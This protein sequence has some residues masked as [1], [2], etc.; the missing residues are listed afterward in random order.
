MQGYR[1]P[2]GNYRRPGRRRKR[3]RMNP[4][5]LIITVALSL[6]AVFV[7]ALI[8]R[9][10]NPA[11]EAVAQQTPSSD[12]GALVSV[13]A[14]GLATPT[15][16]PAPTPEATPEPAPEPTPEP[17]A[18]YNVVKPT[19]TEEGYLPICRKGETNEKIICITVDDCFQ[20]KNTRTIIDLVLS[21][22]GKITLFPIGKNVLRE[23]LQDT[24]RYAYDMGMEIENHTYEHRPHYNKDDELMARQI[25]MQKACVDYVLGVDYEQHFF[26]P[27]GGDGRDDQRMHIYCEQ[28]GIYGV[29]YWSVSGSDSDIARIKSSLSPGQVYL[30]HTTDSDL[31]KLK[32]FIPYAVEQGYTLVTMNEMFGLPENEVKPLDGPV[33]DRTI[34]QIG[35]YTLN[36]RTYKEGD[37]A[38]MAYLIQE[39]LIAQGYLEGEPDG[40]YGPGTAEAVSKFQKDHGLTPTGEADPEMQ[41]LLFGA[42]D[43]GQSAAAEETPEPAE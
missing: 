31:T 26:R 33:E 21:Y 35:E 8:V 23:E 13:I 39:E 4:A 16:E 27:M 22:N 19:P 34:P 42:A 14:E 25:Y 5:A 41:E 36:P 43:G 29:A 38:W 18:Q 9:G 32:E 37:Y 24:I 1:K 17:A 6:A 3:R 15:P 30:F 40:I 28:L 7:V 12:G 2:G 10:R 20:F 11:T